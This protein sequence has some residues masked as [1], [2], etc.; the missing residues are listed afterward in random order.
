MSEKKGNEIAVLTDTSSKIQRVEAEIKKME[1]LRDES[2]KTPGKINLSGGGSVDVSKETDNEKLVL[3]LASIL[4]RANAQELA[5][6]KVGLG[7]NHPVVKIDGASSEG[8]IHDIKLRIQINNQQARFDK[9]NEF[10]KKYEAEMDKTD[11][12]K[13]LDKD[14]ES[15][16]DS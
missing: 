14:F 13:K 11:R 12:I 2:T 1:L 6:E 16:L 8:W 10:K 7:G 5:Y 9:L 4:L 15:F 3:G